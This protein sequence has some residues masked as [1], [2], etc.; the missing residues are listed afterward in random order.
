M[1]NYA[2]SEICF[3][4]KM[5][6]FRTFYL[7]GQENGFFLN[8]MLEFSCYIGSVVHKTLMSGLEESILL[9]FFGVCFSM[10]IKTGKLYRPQKQ[11]KKCILLLKSAI[12][13]K[14]T[15]KIAHV[16]PDVQQQYIGIIFNIFHENLCNFYTAVIES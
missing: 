11:T 4:Q 3:K 10:V 9:F 15:S 7:L 12:Y 1:E 6:G 13:R 2:R 16:V 8:E 5:F 14:L